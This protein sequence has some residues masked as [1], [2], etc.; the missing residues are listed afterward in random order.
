[1]NRSRTIP[2]VIAAIALLSFAFVTPAVSAQSTGSGT[3][4]VVY[5]INAS[6]P[7]RTVSATVNET[8]VQS[9]NSALASVTLQVI[10]SS[11]NLSYSKLVNATHKLL[12]ILP[13]LGTR[14]I[15]LTRG[16]A[17]LSASV[18]QTGTQSVTFSGANYNLTDYSFSISVQTAHKSGTANGQ[19]SVFPSGLVYSATID[20]NGTRTISAQL[21]STN[22]PL[23]A[24]AS[25]GSTTTTTIAVTGASVSVAAGVGAFAFIKHGRKESSGA[26]SEAKPLHWVD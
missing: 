3:H 13:A 14:S 20:I 4:Y 21:L 2:L 1:M 9:S 25:S 23:G 8:V 6:G 24:P 12:P 16:N 17:S 22:I 11:A 19:L 5:R 15:H 7:N 26:N 18:T 10:S